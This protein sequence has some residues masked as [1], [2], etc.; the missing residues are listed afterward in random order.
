MFKNIH[1]IINPAAGQKEPVLNYINDA[2]HKSGIEWTLD[3]TKKIEDAY[4]MTKKAVKKGADAIAVYGGDGTVMQVAQ[5]LHK[6]TVPLLILPGG[7][8]N[9]MSKE[10]Q[11]PQSTQEM[12]EHVKNKRIKVKKVD[13]AVLNKTPFLIRVNVGLFSDMVHKTDRNLKNNLGQVAYGLTTVKQLLNQETIQYTINIDGKQI[14]EEGVGL[15]VANSGNIGVSGVSL[16]PN[17]D[18][19]DGLLDVILFKT[20]NVP[21]LIEWVKSTVAQKKPTGAIKQWKAKE[22][23]ITVSPKQTIIC[24]DITINTKKIKAKIVPESIHLIVP[25]N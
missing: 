23:E 14:A 5:A 24:D 22:V 8:A 2:L 15:M 12:L 9:V 11:I 20:A 25:K 21:S 17:I 16:L 10:L 1:F 6:S 4:I 19:S 18:I 7:T 13:M 3:V